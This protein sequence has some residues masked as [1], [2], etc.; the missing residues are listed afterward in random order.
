MELKIT[1]INNI[2]PMLQQLKKELDNIPKEAHKEFVKVTPIKTGNAKRK[3]R[4]DND[5]IVADY[6]YAEVLD[7]GRHMTPRGLRGSEQAPKGMTEP[8][9]DFIKKRLSQI[10]RGK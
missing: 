2:S 5:T 3:T 8:T 9:V 4:L 10:V 7:K 6:N 1:V